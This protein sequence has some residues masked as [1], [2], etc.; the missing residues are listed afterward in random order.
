MSRG[1]CD[2]GSCT[3]DLTQHLTIYINKKAF[4]SMQNKQGSEI[5]YFFRLLIERVRHLKT[6]ENFSFF[7]KIFFYSED[8]QIKIYLSL[9]IRY[10]LF[11]MIQILKILLFIL[12]GSFLAAK[13][14]RH[15]VTCHVDYLT[16][17]TKIF[18][19]DIVKSESGI[20][21]YSPIFSRIN[22]GKENPFF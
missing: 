19:S 5:F 1:S 17:I 16:Q 6:K 22:R 12:N 21:M 11:I 13:F 2:W 15:Q 20:F 7:D 9:S 3:W 18:T 4:K 14:P 10:L 8:M